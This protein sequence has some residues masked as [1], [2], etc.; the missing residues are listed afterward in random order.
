MVFGLV[1]GFFTYLFWWGGL[2]VCI[3]VSLSLVTF[4]F[5]HSFYF[6]FKEMWTIPFK[7]SI[8]MSLML[9]LQLTAGFQA[10]HVSHNDNKLID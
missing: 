8:Q 9:F 3:F 5:F 6:L 10:V 7:F 1:L 4:G 2:F